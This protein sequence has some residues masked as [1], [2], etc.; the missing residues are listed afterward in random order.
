MQVGTPAQ[1][2]RLL[3]GTSAT[4]CTAIWVVL[5][6]GCIA[7]DPSDCASLRGFVFKPNQSLTWSTKTLQN[8]GLY[9]L[10]TFEESLLGYAGNALYGYDNLTLGWQGSRL[11]TLSNQLVAGIATKDFYIGSLGL[12]PIPSNL[13]TFNE[14]QPSMLE[15][16][17]NQS[18][19][20]SSSWAYTAG[21][22]YQDPKVFGSLTLGGYD[23]SR[24]SS[25]NVTFSFGADISR[26]LLV[27][28]Q[29]IS[30]DTTSYPLLKNG[31]YAFVNSLVPHIWL[32]ID[33][34]TAFEEAF[35]LTW[36]STT[37]LY[38]LTED[39]HQKLVERNANLTFKLGP[40]ATSGSF[41]E[42]VMPYGA[43]DLTVNSPIVNNATRYFPIRRAQNNTQYTL[44][45]VF[46]QQ[47]YVIADY[48]RSNF[49]VSQALFPNTSVRQNIVA[50]LP[51]DVS[52]PTHRNGLS[53]GALAGIVVAIVA[54][55]V[56]FV[57]VV[58]LL[59]YRRRRE[60]DA[61]N[62]VPVT[63]TREEENARFEKAELEAT[64]TSKFELNGATRDP[65]ELHTTHTSRVPNA[66]TELPTDRTVFARQELPNFAANGVA[67]E[68]TYEMPADD[69]RRPELEGS[70]PGP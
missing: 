23:A 34:C 3:P 25:N 24:F 10:Y 32:P 18:F 13:S 62:G 6:E 27:G 54:F 36:D 21:A 19:I 48:D 26:D 8:G 59:R 61:A 50:V 38:L 31:I 43:F 65:I 17:R 41:V 16:L 5:P 15:T 64:D 63:H 42:I 47:A 53:I 67:H 46:L 39:Q 9:S 68:F 58:Y 55:C 4:S 22:F 11:P 14:P 29:L 45:R 66:G 57:L 60:E 20:P 28:I 69:V 1:N 30:S 37:D 70:H 35:N 51:P 49:S 44:G 7:G 12:S 33:V 52:Q 2:V 56:T 40:S